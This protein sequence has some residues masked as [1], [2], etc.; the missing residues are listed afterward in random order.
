[1]AIQP[2]SG[3]HVPN[4]INGGRLSEYDGE[5]QDYSSVR[6]H[7]HPGML[8][9]PTQSLQGKALPSTARTQA[10]GQ[11]LDYPEWSAVLSE[12][13]DSCSGRLMSSLH[14]GPDTADAGILLQ[15]LMAHPRLCGEN[16]KC[17]VALFG[18]NAV[19]DLSMC[20]LDLARTCVQAHQQAVRRFLS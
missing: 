19:C 20:I 8:P 13:F 14:L 11:P 9:T 12:V 18:R 6:P 1:M 5:F 17:G 2:G 15:Q 7:P 10:G 16:G 3:N 4:F